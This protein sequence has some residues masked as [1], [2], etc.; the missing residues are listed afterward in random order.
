MF[1]WYMPSSAK[2]PLE[3]KWGKDGMPYIEGKGAYVQMLQS[4]GFFTAAFCAMVARYLDKCELEGRDV[5]AME[6]FECVD[7]DLLT[8]APF[9]KLVDIRNLRAQGDEHRKE[10]ELVLVGSYESLIDPQTP[11]VAE[12]NLRFSL[13]AEGG[14]WKVDRAYTTMGYMESWGLKWE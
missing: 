8:H 7:Y 11:T 5:P 14:K 4:S 1:E 13:V 9:S 3:T 10:V 2:Y 6:R 12:S